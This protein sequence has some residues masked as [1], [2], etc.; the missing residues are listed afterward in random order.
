MDCTKTPNRICPITSLIQW[1]GVYDEGA[2]QAW[3]S[4]TGQKDEHN[5]LSAGQEA[6]QIQG[7]VGEVIKDLQALSLCE[8][9]PNEQMRRDFILS[10]H[11]RK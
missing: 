2:L 10:R 6:A 5:V 1:A 4:Q 11:A 3:Q 8:D 9:C 7:G